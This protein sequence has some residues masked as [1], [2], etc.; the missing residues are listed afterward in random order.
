MPVDK[1]TV[2]ALLNQMVGMV[3]N[4]VNPDARIGEA[5]IVMEVIQPDGTK[6]VRVA[7]TGSTFSGVGLLAMAK[8]ILLQGGAPQLTFVPPNPN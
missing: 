2:D 5:C 8:S 3:E 4:Q 7:H 6:G 1:T